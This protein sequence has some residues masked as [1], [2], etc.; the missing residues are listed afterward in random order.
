MHNAVKHGAGGKILVDLHED[1]NAIILNIANRGTLV[2]AME[3]A[4]GIGLSSM[5]NRAKLLDAQLDITQVGTE[6]SV[7]VALDKRAAQTMREQGKKL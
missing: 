2:A 4:E 6:V 1:E 7:R 5:R 3:A